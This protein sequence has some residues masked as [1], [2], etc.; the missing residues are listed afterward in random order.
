VTEYLRFMTYTQMEKAYRR[1][2]ARRTRQKRGTRLT[3]YRGIAD[4]VDG[5]AWIG[6]ERSVR[7]TP[8][9]LMITGGHAN[10]RPIRQLSHAH[11]R[12]TA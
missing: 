2:L 10:A 7:L 6:K 9:R 1:I 11:E 3:Q 4:T 8:L 5:S 12:I